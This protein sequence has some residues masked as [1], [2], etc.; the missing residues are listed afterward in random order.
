MDNKK[1]GL[2]IK[3]KRTFLGL[4]QKELANE[5]NITDKAI[6]K[7]ET[8]LGLP[9]ISLLEPLSKILGVTVTEILNGT[10]IEDTIK[11]SDADNY[12]IESINYSKNKYKNTINK[13]ITF[14]IV[15]ISLILVI[16]NI[17]NIYNQHK[18]YY[19][20]DIQNINTYQTMMNEDIKEIKNNFKI[21]KNSRG[22]YSDDDYKLIIKAISDINSSIDENILINYD[23]RGLKLN[24]LLLT[25]NKNNI[26]TPLFSLSYIINNNSKEN[27]DML[28][29][30]RYALLCRYSSYNDWQ[31]MYKYE[32]FDPLNSIYVDFVTPYNALRN[33]LYITIS[34]IKFLKVITNELIKVGD[35]HE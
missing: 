17:I 24:E 28:N 34:D 29:A 3:E 22:K 11:L 8:G 35:I 7:W 15:F 31:L 21:I 16:L 19:L 25:G 18:D 12:I 13:I 6:S 23:G 14:L 1:I 26:V 30:F 10:D 2:F 9:D 4:T 20:D 27:T 33:Q 32:L 5:L